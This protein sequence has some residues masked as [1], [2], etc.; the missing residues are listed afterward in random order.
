MASELDDHLSQLGSSTSDNRYRLAAL[1]NEE[2]MMKF[3]VHMRDKEITHIELE[4]AQE[5]A[6][7]ETVHRRQ[8]ETREQEI[9]LCKMDIMKLKE[10]SEV[11]R[12]QLQLAQLQQS[13]SVAT[14]STAGP[15]RSFIPTSFH[16]SSSTSF[17]FF[18]PGPSNA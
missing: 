13:N 10:E 2:K 6:E 9:E 4:R 5:R 18:D 16:G 8:V 17:P 12:L 1:E 14:T 11:L 7:A 15:S 3:Q